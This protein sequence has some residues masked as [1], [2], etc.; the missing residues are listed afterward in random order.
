MRAYLHAF[1]FQSGGLAEA[2][3]GEGAAN[4]DIVIV[5]MTWL[6]IPE[7]LNHL[8]NFLEEKIVINVSNLFPGTG[9]IW[10]LSKPTAL[11]F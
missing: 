2:G 3:S 6:K 10:V 1:T 9:S 8:G 4:A 5:A 11:R 7:V